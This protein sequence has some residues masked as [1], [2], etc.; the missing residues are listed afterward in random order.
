[1]IQWITVD[2]VRLMHSIEFMASAI[3]YHKNSNIF[4]GVCTI[5]SDIF[6]HPD[7]EKGTFLTLKQ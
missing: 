2:T 6:I 1:M 3:Y 7:D 5:V 4:T